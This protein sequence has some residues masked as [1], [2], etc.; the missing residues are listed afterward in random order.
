MARNKS[1]GKDKIP[2]RVIKDC[3]PAI[4][5]SVTSIINATLRSAQ[6]P[7]AWKVAEVT[8]ILKDSDQEI[9]NN[10]R[11]ISLLPLLSKIRE[12]VAHDQLTFYFGS[13]PTLDSYS[14][15]RQ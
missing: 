10:Y 6:F 4:S 14:A 13:E 1:A 8:P 12:R 9:P 3:L 5:P 11:P 2:L 7:F 15:A